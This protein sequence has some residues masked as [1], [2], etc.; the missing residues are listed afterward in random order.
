METEA[1]FPKGQV[2]TTRL[3]A[4][5]EQI[6]SWQVTPGSVTLQPRNAKCEAVGTLQSKRSGAPYLCDSKEAAEGSSNIF[7]INTTF[8]EQSLQLDPRLCVCVCVRV[9]VCA[10]CSSM[11]SFIF[12]TCNFPKN[13]PVSTK[14]CSVSYMVIT[15]DCN[16][17]H[18]YPSVIPTQ[19]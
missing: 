2:T 12:H 5:E 19:K 1:P 13:L 3:L 14:V 11:H 10:K 15:T 9:H 4:A 8:T 6:C 7:K 18:N 16:R 17:S